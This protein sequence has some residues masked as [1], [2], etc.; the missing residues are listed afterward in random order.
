MGERDGT[1]L[2]RRSL[3]RGAA[4]AA[5]LTGMGPA[6]PAAAAPATAPALLPRTRT[7]L[8][9]GL[10]AARAGAATR[11]DGARVTL[12]ER[13]RLAS[14][15]SAVA[16]LLPDGVDHAYVRA[17]G[18]GGDHPWQ[19]LS[20]LVDGPDGGSSTAATDLSW[21]RAV[22]ELEVAV[23]DGAAIEELGVQLF[24][25]LGL[26]DA[27]AGG[28]VAALLE[29]LLAPLDGDLLAPAEEVVDGL[30]GS[31][32]GLLD[33][34]GSPDAAPG[35]GIS[36]AR[37]AMVRR[38]DWGAAAPRQRHG[39]ASVRAVVL[40]HTV[41]R[42]DYTTR[43]APA[44]VRAIQAHH[45]RTMG[46]SDIGYNFLIDRYGGVYEGR[47]GGI[48]A[49]VVGAHAAGYN[50]GTSGVSI[51]GNYES[52]GATRSGLD[53][54]AHV[55]AWQARIHRIDLQDGARTTVSGRSIPTFLSHRDVGS[56]ACP[57]QNLYDRLPEIRRLARSAR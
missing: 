51:I 20:R 37:P 47:A 2:S 44:I 33:G 18:P 22:D 5:V 15:V 45:Q 6:S 8:L 11:L 10:A 38:A 43:E 23:P 56:T 32:T 13:L 48:E 25:T 19:R 52:G 27:A 29:Q 46:W 9:R 24:D 55:L 4:A 3:L 53:R 30:V 16:L 54:A 49:G 26:T 21:L 42:N 40:H 41:N 57:G 7:G 1:R 50:T 28:D 17:S 36:H 31:V 34:D 14:P 39:T 12:G 35:T